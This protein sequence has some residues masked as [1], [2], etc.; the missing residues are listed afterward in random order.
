MSHTD[1]WMY[2]AEQ[3]RQRGW[4]GADFGRVSGIDRSRINA[5]R[6]RGVMP[7]VQI[8]RQVAEA[9][10]VPVLTVFVAAG[11]LH[12]EE[13]GAPADAPLNLARVSDDALLDE[14]GRRLRTLRM[15]APTPEEV[16]SDPALVAP[17]IA[18]EVKRAE[19]EAGHYG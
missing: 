9:F 4:S 7:S 15:R 17:N 11:F 18:F 1:W 10:E 19:K 14:F 6:D 16:Q 2:I 5:W 13:I 3:L 12:P 8:A